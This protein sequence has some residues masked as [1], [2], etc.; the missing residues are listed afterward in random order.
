LNRSELVRAEP[1]GIYNWY[2]VTS[3]SKLESQF[4]DD[5]N[6]LSYGQEK[7]MKVQKKVSLNDPNFGA[8]W[9]L[10]NTGN[11]LLIVSSEVKIGQVDGATS[12]NDINVVSAWDGGIT[13]NGILIQLVDD[14]LDFTHPDFES[15]YV[16]SARSEIMYTKVTVLT[17]LT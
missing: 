7:L 3:Q 6:V 8:Q 5:Q 9:H 12:G 4:K 16:A 2:L 13:G 17:A 14:G 11:S 15:K 10:Q 1:L